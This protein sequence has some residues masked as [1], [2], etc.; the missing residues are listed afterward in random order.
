MTGWWLISYLVLWTLVALLC[1]VALVVLRQ[2][3]LMYARDERLSSLPGPRQGEAVGP[4]DMS[5]ARSGEPVTFPHPAKPLSLMIFVS[6]ECSLCK[7]A[8]AGIDALNHDDDLWIVVV[9]TGDAGA[10]ESL[11]ALLG[12]QT[13][14]VV[15]EEMH[16]ALEIPFVPWSLLV[17]RAGVVRQGRPINRPGDLQTMLDE[18]GEV[19]SEKHSLNP[20][21]I[22]EVR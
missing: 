2:L 7:E 11:R 14:L 18:F 8:L 5:D 13:A 10:I 3:G 9:S 15:S 16:R 20:L 12:D 21:Q 17:D 1:L 4:L 19:P 22:E 6:P